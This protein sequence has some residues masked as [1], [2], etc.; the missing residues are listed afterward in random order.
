[1]HSL[2]IVGSDQQNTLERSYAY[3]FHE[4]G[5]QVHFWDPV[6]SLSQV[7]RGGR[8]GRMFSSF[9]SVEPWVRKANRS[10]TLRAIQL[11][12]DL[13]FIFSHHPIQIGALSQ[14]RVSTKAALVHI[15]PDTMVNWPT[16]LSVCLPLY[17]LVATYSRATVSIFEQLGA[18]RVVWVPLAGDP[19]LH[20]DV[21]CSDEDRRRFGAQVTFIGGWR[22]EREAVLSRLGDVDLKIW[23]P[24]WGRRCKGNPVIM[25]AWQKRAI[26]GQEFA[27]AVKGSQVNLNI[28]DPTNYP[29]ANMRFF[30]IPM[31]GG[32][33][34]SSTCPEMTPTFRHGEHLFY[35]DSVD[36]LPDRIASLLEDEECR[37]EIATAAHAQVMAG[38]TYTH[39]A[40]AILQH[41]EGA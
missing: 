24:E 17:D 30:E 15:W 25:K 19:T 4:L 37:N 21:I 35:Y 28:I 29:A 13:V 11:Q 34:V 41:L 6:Q 3:A 27:K 20:P 38:H 16:E 33:Q 8:I 26:F 9:V 2:L 12:P 36:E 5:W 1:M 39:R 14:I 31:A 23:G 40:R 22:P 32:M 7:V 18:R 10:L